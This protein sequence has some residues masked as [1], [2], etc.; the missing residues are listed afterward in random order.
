MFPRIRLLAL[1]VRTVLRAK[2]AQGSDKHLT[3]LQST[4][5]GSRCANQLAGSDAN[6]KGKEN[7]TLHG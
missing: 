3:A 2:F 4:V 5:K 1:H 6:G 7:C